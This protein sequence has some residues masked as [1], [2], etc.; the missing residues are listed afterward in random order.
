MTREIEER[1]EEIEE[2][3]EEEIEEEIEEEKVEKE[4]IEEEIEVKK[5]KKEEVIE[6]VEE[7]KEEVKLY[8][9]LPSHMEKYVNDV[10]DLVKKT[11]EAFVNRRKRVV[12]TLL[13]ISRGK[14][15][16]YLNVIL[17]MFQMY[18]KKFRFR[19]CFP[20]VYI[21]TPG[22]SLQL[23]Y[24][25]FIESKLQNFINNKYVHEVPVIKHVVIMGKKHYKCPWAKQKGLDEKKK[26][27]IKCYKCPYFVKWRSVEYPASVVSEV[28]TEITPS[29][30]E[31]M[32][33]NLFGEYVDLK[34]PELTDI[35]CAYAQNFKAIY[36]FIRSN[37][38]T[39]IGVLEPKFTNELLIV[40]INYDAFLRH[41][42][43][44]PRGFLVIFDEYDDYILDAINIR[45]DQKLITELV[46]VAKKLKSPAALKILSTYTTIISRKPVNQP[47]RELL[48]DWLL[49]VKDL[50][51][52]V[53]RTEEVE[54]S[55]DTLNFCYA[56]R[57]AQELAFTKRIYYDEGII[58][59]A[60]DRHPIMSIVINN[61]PT[62]LASGTPF[63]QNTVRKLL[64][65]VTS[66]EGYDPFEFI[67]PS[68][69]ELKRPPGEVVVHLF[70]F[71]DVVT[72][73]KLFERHVPNRQRFI[74]YCSKLGK[75]LDF[76]LNNSDVYLP[77]LILPYPWY[78]L[79]Y[80]IQLSHDKEVLEKHPEFEHFRKI[81]QF[82]D[83]GSEEFRELF[84]RFL[85]TCSTSYICRDLLP[86][87]DEI[88]E[89]VENNEATFEEMLMYKEIIDLLKRSEEEGKKETIFNKC[90]QFSIFRNDI[91]KYLATNRLQRG[92]DLTG[93][94]SIIFVKFPLDNI[95][96]AFAKLC[97]RKVGLDV[98]YDIAEHRLQQVIGRGVRRPYVKVH[99][100]TPD[101][102]VYYALI[103]LGR[104]GLLSVKVVVHE[105]TGEVKE[106]EITK[107]IEEAEKQIEELKKKLSEI[108]KEPKAIEYRQEMKIEVL[109]ENEKEFSTVITM[110]TQ[111]EKKENNQ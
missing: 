53:I 100:F 1:E 93:L 72:Y 96:S 75:I 8:I 94:R 43:K 108:K 105:E 55:E 106:E 2:V 80:C 95:T 63:P 39:G 47:I 57:E 44:L 97:S 9:K 32:F 5:E 71:M 103:R 76:I 79:M 45:I 23:Y 16:Y 73:R 83:K 10:Y 101:K 92:N 24:A 86:R 74:E 68:N 6:E 21:V 35:P 34:I 50:C 60:F 13:G 85:D 51:Y 99:V 77:V 30:T 109:E 87:L 88:K 17:N 52:D 54:V 91:V 46:E 59:L 82:I 41:V 89:K 104:L 62:V 49:T 65:Y 37:S 36:D 38:R 27:L 107:Y 102:N 22:I 70:D 81:S 12:H 4:E 110:P 61:V 15:W 78:C 111:L 7:E 11:V 84:R 3:E 28:G 14:T 48:V 26:H 66:R 31:I 56:I 20:I 25:D 33:L 98:L 18:K 58:E 29:E 40:I 19:K 90:K 64:R 42:R 67:E 69:P